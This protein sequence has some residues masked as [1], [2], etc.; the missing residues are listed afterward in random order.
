MSY[1]GIVKKNTIRAFSD[2]VFS[3]ME[4]HGFEQGERII[5]TKSGCNIYNIRSLDG[6]KT[7]WAM[8]FEVEMVQKDS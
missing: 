6:S 3:G 1:E 2:D 4:N 5:A 7:G 8:D